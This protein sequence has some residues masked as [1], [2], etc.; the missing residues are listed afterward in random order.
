[1]ASRSLGPP[2]LSCQPRLEGHRP[3]VVT[4]LAP[5]RSVNRQ[6]SMCAALSRSTVGQVLPKSLSVWW[7]SLPGPHSLVKVQ[8]LLV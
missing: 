8:T 3:L 2:L 1:M 5:A 7:A 6:P 4:D